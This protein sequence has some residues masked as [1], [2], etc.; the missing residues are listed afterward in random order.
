MAFSIYFYKS[1]YIVI[2]NFSRSAKLG[3]N[4]YYCYISLILFLII[5][6]SSFSIYSCSFNY[7]V[8]S[9]FYTP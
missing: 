3:Y 4:C 8:F 1:S 7:S 5:I 2:L 9:L 6:I